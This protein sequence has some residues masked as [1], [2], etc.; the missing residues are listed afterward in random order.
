MSSSGSLGTGDIVGISVGGI[1]AV[2]SIIGILMT[3]YSLCCSNKSK[4][5]VQPKPS[6]QNQ[7]KPSYQNQPNPSYQNQPN[8]SYQNQQN[9][10]GQQINH[11]YYAQQQSW[12][13]Q[14]QPWPPQQQYGNP[15]QMSNGQRP[16]YQY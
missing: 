12:P 7:P 15:G 10:Y 1:L 9:P 4:P 5:K 6:Y 3:C 14:Q 11:G 16:V 2:V 13:P 8:P